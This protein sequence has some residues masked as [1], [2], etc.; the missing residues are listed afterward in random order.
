[1]IGKVIMKWVRKSCK[2]HLVSQQRFIL[3][4]LPKVWKKKLLILSYS[5][6]ENTVG[7]LHAP[8]KWRMIVHLSSKPPQTFTTTADTFLGARKK[9]VL[10]VSDKVKAHVHLRIYFKAHFH[11]LL[12]GK[13]INS[14]FLCCDRYLLQWI[15][16]RE[17]QHGS[18]S[19]CMVSGT[20][21]NS[22]T[23]DCS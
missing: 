5:V 18:E 12:L 21:L 17:N 22:S 4:I 14:M 10:D 15:F 13:K 11:N 23:P 19:P 7:T 1:M 9:K 20:P 3:L 2:V 16:E 6:A 8:L